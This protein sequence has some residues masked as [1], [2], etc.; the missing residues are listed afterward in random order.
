MLP[1]FMPATRRM[2]WQS[3]LVRLVISPYFNLQ[4]GFGELEASAIE[5]SALS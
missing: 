5:L 3:S 1:V 2:V 4:Q